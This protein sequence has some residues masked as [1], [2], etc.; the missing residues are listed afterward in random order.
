MTS[1]KTPAQKRTKVPRAVDLTRPFLKDWERLEHSG[2]YDLPR[3]KHA[4][5]LLIANDA[6]MPAEYS[7][8]PLKGEWRDFRECHV[9]GDFLLIYRL[10]EDGLIVFSRTGTHSE[11]FRR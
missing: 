7:D 10:P 4:M 8:H 3:L 2:R 5:M 1:K 6:P 9:G 11:L